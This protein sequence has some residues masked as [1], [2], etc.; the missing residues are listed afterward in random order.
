MWFNERTLE[1]GGRITVPNSKVCSGEGVVSTV[2]KQGVYVVY[3][4]PVGGFIKNQSCFY[5]YD[6]L[7]YWYGSNKPANE[8]N[9]KIPF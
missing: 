6:Y 4:E 3:S 2:T 1:L 7:N 5:S 8:L 9:D